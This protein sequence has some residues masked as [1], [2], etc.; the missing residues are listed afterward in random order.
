MHGIVT[1]SRP[2][3]FFC[4]TNFVVYFSNPAGNRST[5][6]C[7]YPIRPGLLDTVFH[8]LLQFDSII[9]FTR[10]IDALQFIHVY[11]GDG[12]KDNFSFRLDHRILHEWFI[13]VLPN[14]K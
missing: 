2:Q 12:R 4:C 5:A 14:N 8:K 9:G 3:C 13:G 6:T 7:Q 11:A 1:A 10:Y